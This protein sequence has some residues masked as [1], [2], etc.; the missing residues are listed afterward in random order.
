VTHYSDD[1]QQR[2]QPRFPFPWLIL[3]R[4]YVARQ[5]IDIKRQ[6]ASLELDIQQIGVKVSAV[7]DVLVQLNDA[8]NLV[9]AR[10][11]TVVGTLDAETAAKIQPYVDHLK[12]LA[13]DPNNPVPPPPVE[14]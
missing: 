7:D 11:E 4:R 5:F 10:L 12:E 1:D 2:R 14:G 13:A 6:L 8:T 3:S 9:A